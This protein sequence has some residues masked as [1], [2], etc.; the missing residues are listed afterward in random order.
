MRIRWKLLIFLLI[1]VLAPII[2]VRWYSIRETRTLG[3]ELAINAAEVMRDTANRELSQTVNMFAEAVNDS[4]DVL[5]LALTLQARETERLLAERPQHVEPYFFDTDFDRRDPRIGVLEPPRILSDSSAAHTAKADIPI[6]TD[7]LVFRLS[8]DADVPA[9][10]RDARALTRLLP[11]F[12]I[13]YLRHDDLMLWSY[14]SLDNGLHCAYP[15]HGGYPPDYDPRRR[16][17][18]TQAKAQGRPVWNIMVDANTHRAIATLSMP[19]HAPDGSIIGVTGVD[20]PLDTLLLESDLSQRWTPAVRSMLLRPAAEADGDPDGML[21]VAM[22]DYIE[23]GTDW[24]TP[25]ALESLEKEDPAS[26]E[27]MREDIKQNR[28]GIVEMPYRG[29]PSV[30]AFKPVIQ[31]GLTLAVIVPSEVIVASSRRAEESVMERTTRMLRDTSVFALAINI[32]L[33]AVAAVA[34]LAITRPIARLARAAGRIAEGDLTARA[35]V[36]S[37]DELGDLAKA[38]NAMAPKLLERV[39]L[40]NDMALAME[41]QRNLLPERPPVVPGLDIAAACQFCDETGGDYYDFLSFSRERGETLDI[42]LGDVTGHG[43]S[44]ALFM[45]TGRALLHARTEDDS[46]PARC[47]SMVNRLLCR[48]TQSTGRF[49]TL[50]F[51]SMQLDTGELAWVRAGHDPALIYAPGTDSFEELGGPGIPL[52]VEEGWEYRAN[53]RRGLEAGQ[54]MVLGTDGI[55]EAMDPAGEMFGKE[56]FKAVLRANAGRTAQEI[57]D[58]VVDE[59]MA[60]VSPGRPED[61]LTLVIIKALR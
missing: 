27:A 49:I 12:R 53:Q 47:I 26:L 25:L 5:E 10:L 52:G 45:A 17:W 58:A 4:R 21:I 50:F 18:Y 57:V 22:R 28:Q 61:D 60:F 29:V 3:T 34:S 38:F 20:F 44:A 46:D 13:I 54:L 16:E 39:K 41:V 35:E 6:S 9:A 1:F 7:H 56:R 42:I 36:K 14:V 15:G 48:D 37:H 24:R 51:L 59:V 40:K 23:H 8:P 2:L 55:W 31:D 43:I 33:V 32:L 19:I 11:I 30:W